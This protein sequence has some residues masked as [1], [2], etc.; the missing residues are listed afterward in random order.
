MGSPCECFCP[1][2]IVLCVG[3]PHAITADDFFFFFWC[4]RLWKDRKG[5]FS[6][7]LLFFLGKY[8]EES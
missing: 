7:S 8:G 3:M 1:L 6:F 4:I 5:A 2:I